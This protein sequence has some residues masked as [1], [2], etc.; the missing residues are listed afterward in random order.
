LSPSDRLKSLK[1]PLNV[2]AWDLRKF[3]TLYETII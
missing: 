1:K 3:T 2:A